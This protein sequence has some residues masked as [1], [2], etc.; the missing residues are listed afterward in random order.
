LYE[1]THVQVYVRE[2]PG[3]YGISICGSG[4]YNAFQCKYLMEY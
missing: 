4:Q 1:Y 2:S 3:M